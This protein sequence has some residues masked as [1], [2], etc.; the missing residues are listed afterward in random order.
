LAAMT[1]KVQAEDESGDAINGI[2]KSI[3]RVHG[4][5]G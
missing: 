2:G 1:G 3:Q 5:S 4:S